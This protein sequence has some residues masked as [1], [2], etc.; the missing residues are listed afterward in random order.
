[1]KDEISVL[2]ETINQMTQ[3][4]VKAATASKDLTVGKE[5]QKM[6]IPLEKDAGGK[7]LTTGK[8]TNKHVEFFGYYEGAKGVS[9]DYFD[10]LKID[11][12]HYAIIKCDVAGKG[13]PAALIMVEVATIFL[14]YFREWSVKK[15]GV[16]I[17]QLAYRINDLLEERGFKGRFAALIIVIMNMETGT[18]YLCN[19]GDNII[20]LFDRGKRQ[21][22]QKILPEAPAAGVFPSMLVEMQSGFKQI[23]LKLTA[24]DCMFLF[25][26]G[27]E[28]AKRIFRDQA[29]KPI[30]CQEP[31]LKDG[32]LHE[33]HPRS[34]GDEE[35]GIP[36]IYDIINSVMD[37]K[38]Y[39][40][41]KYHNPVENE[42]LTFDF[43]TCEGTIEEAILAM[44]SVEKIFRI[45]PDPSAT[46]ENKIIV[47][48]KVDEFLKAH[49]DQYRDYF[50]HLLDGG[51][52]TEY[53]HFSHLK[54]D[55]QYDDLTILGIKKL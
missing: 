44:V 28:E 20:H 13:V 49:F 18:C 17:D 26:D 23:P 7:K 10:F 42:V 9:G 16:H 29:F 54:E 51:P 8:E 50:S 4:L 31:G 37:R 22:I 55:E 38:K 35:L 30:T 34:S 53:V 40:L 14:T 2:A 3:G 15:Q 45:Y 12:K 27:I 33:T 1:S 41:Y 46:G 6:Y 47:D 5:V 43:T 52:V 24:G 19:A 25:T 39:S 21:M 32:E 36:R 48:R 11:E